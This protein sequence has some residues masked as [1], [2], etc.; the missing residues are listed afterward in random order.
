VLGE[1]KT[2]GMNAISPLRLLFT[3]T[4]CLIFCDVW[5]GF[6]ICF[7]YDLKDNE[8][9]N[10]KF[11]LSEGGE[12]FVRYKNGTAD[13]KIIKIND[14]NLV[15]KNQLPTTVVS[16]WKEV[17]NGAVTGY[18]YLA[19][20]GSVVG[21]LQYLRSKDKKLFNFYDDRQNPDLNCSWD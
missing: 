10:L 15:K 4:L 20:H 2:F 21:G 11:T 16:K 8:A 1:I 17:V 18:Y 5:A 13:I 9:V 7:Q 12:G 6:S 19:V 14:K 3:L